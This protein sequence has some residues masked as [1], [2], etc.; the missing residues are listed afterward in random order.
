MSS[1]TMAAGNT[2]AA[3]TR[4]PIKPIDDQR[5]AQWAIEQFLER[6]RLRADVHLDAYRQITAPHGAL[7]RCGI[8]SAALLRRCAERARDRGNA[9]LNRAIALAKVVRDAD[10][11]RRATAISMQYAPQISISLHDQT[12]YARVFDSMKRALHTLHGTSRQPGIVWPEL[13]DVMPWRSTE[14]AQM[15]AADDIKRG[16]LLSVGN[17]GLAHLFSPKEKAA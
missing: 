14:R 3:S 7:A 13:I 17:D 5:D 4:R 6:Q 12:D 9:M 11:R 16:Q 8:F 10:T 1:A 15:V 2:G